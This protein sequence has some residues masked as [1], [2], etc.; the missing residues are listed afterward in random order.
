[1]TNYDQ[2]AHGY[3]GILDVTLMDL[4]PAE[5]IEIQCLSYV[6][7]MLNIEFAAFTERVV[8]SSNVENLPEEILDLLALQYRIPYYDS[9]FS[10]DLKRSLVKEGYQWMMTA[11]TTGCVNRLIQSIFGDG[12]V[13]EWYESTD[14]TMKEGEFD[15][16]IN[17][18]DI[19]EDIVKDFARILKRAKTSHSKLRQVVNNHN[20]EHDIYVIHQMFGVDHVVIS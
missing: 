15:V 8:L 2:F 10:I 18:K 14:P 5:S 17:E 13:V 6:D 20:M 11:G 1:M 19:T 3:K 4:F 16:E 9:D 12:K 7:S